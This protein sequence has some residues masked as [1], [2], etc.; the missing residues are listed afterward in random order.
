MGAT[1]YMTLNTFQL[2]GFM[3]PFRTLEPG[4]ISNSGV[5]SIKTEKLCM[6]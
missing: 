6:S 3:D 2:G 1:P 5:K 4:S